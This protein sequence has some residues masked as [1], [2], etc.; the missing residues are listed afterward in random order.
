MLRKCKIQ[1]TLLDIGT[2]VPVGA[3][4]QTDSH[5]SEDN[6]SICCSKVVCKTRM[7]LFVVNSELIACYMH[8]FVSTVI[9][10]MMICV[11]LCFVHKR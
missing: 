5:S 2:S 6:L 11:S 3:I 10:K 7:S 4:L 9:N 1:F 8:V